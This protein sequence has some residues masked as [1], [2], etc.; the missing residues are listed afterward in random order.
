MTAAQPVVSRT[1]A[2]RQASAVDDALAATTDF[3][4]AQD[5]HAQLR[6]AGVRIG[7]TTVY[8]HLQTLADTEVV[9]VVRTAT[10]ELAYRRCATT[11]HH[12][13]LVCRHCA[14]TVEVE[15]P[16]VES[17][18]DRIAARAG[19]TDI[20]HTVEI[21]GSCPRCTAARA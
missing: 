20:A 11:N 5:L 9:D 18:L 21:A 15:G 19:F 16:E 7:L 12:H 8:R 14:H 13:H 6:A 4:T 10:G 3:R 1:R 17:W 2:T